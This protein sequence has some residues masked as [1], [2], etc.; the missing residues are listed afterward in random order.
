MLA[1]TPGFLCFQQ[2]LLMLVKVAVSSVKFPG[3]L[4]RILVYVA[5]ASDVSL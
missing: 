1:I 4:V 3:L 2:A 5:A